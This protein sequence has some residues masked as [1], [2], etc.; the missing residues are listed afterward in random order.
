MQPAVPSADTAAKDIADLAKS[1]SSNRSKNQE[2][3]TLV[4]DANATQSEPDEKKLSLKNEISEPKKDS[5]KE[6]P[7]IEVQDQ[8][9]INNIKLINIDKKTKIN[10]AYTDKN[11]NIV[12]ENALDSS[13]KEI[14]LR[15]DNKANTI[16]SGN[17]NDDTLAKAQNETYKEKV[18][19]ITV[20]P[21]TITVSQAKDT[22]AK[23][24]K[25][26][27][28]AVAFPATAGQN[29]GS[30]VHNKKR[31]RH[32]TEAPTVDTPVTKSTIIHNYPTYVIKP[33]A[34]VPNKLDSTEGRKY[35]FHEW[36]PGKPDGLNENPAVVKP[37]ESPKKPKHHW[38]KKKNKKKK[39]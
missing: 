26:T 22:A 10:N 14:K 31:K 24:V 27:S 18:M 25:D 32:Q 5:A 19:F 17:R 37:T 4:I 21:T 15:D 2:T 36:V 38:F 23:T 6:Q 29:S 16:V 9:S 28:V 39:D 12:T 11:Q 7:R 20:P 30:E 8:D 34:V 1:N 33:R 13:E 3:D 35:V